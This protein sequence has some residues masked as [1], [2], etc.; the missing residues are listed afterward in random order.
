MSANSLHS[1]LGPSFKVPGADP[2]PPLDVFAKTPSGGGGG[3]A[4]A[5]RKAR[6]AAEAENER[7]FE[8]EHQRQD[9]VKDPPTKPKPVVKLSNGKWLVDK[10]HY[11]EKAKVSLDVERPSDVAADRITFEVCE[12]LPD[13]K[14]GKRHSAGE[15]HLGEGN[16]SVTCDLTLPQ[17]EKVDNKV[18]EKAY[19]QFVAKHLYSDELQG[20]RLEAMPGST[21]PFESVMY[22][23]PTRNQ[24]LLFESYEEYQ[25]LQDEIDSL[26]TLK[27]KSRQAFE[28]TDTGKRKEIGEEID[29][30]AN[31]L[32]EGKV[33]GEKE[34]TLEE[35][36]LVRKPVKWASPPGWA[37][38]RPHTD[39]DGKKI[40]GKWYKDTDPK[41]K[42][43]LED[44]MKKAPGSKEHSPFFSGELTLKLFKTKPLEAKKIAW[45]VKV[46]KEGTIAGQPFT[47]SKE[48]AVCRFMMGWDGAEATAN[49]KDKK[50]HIGGGGKISFGLFEGKMEGEFPWPEKGVNLLELL[51]K[52][53]YLDP[54]L[55]KGRQ[56]LMRLHFTLKADAFAGLT[57]GGALNLL[58]LNLTK[59]KLA[60]GEKK[61]RKV[62]T[63]A[64][65]KGF[66][67]GKADTGL[68]VGVEWA[69]SERDKFGELAN[70]GA[71]VGG[72]VGLGA[73]TEWKIEYRDGVFHF[74][75]GTG[76]TVAL[77]CKGK[78]SFEVGLEEGWHFVGYLLHCMDY[79][80][81]LEITDAAFS[82]YKNYAFTL[83]TLG[84]KA[85]TEDAFLI[86]ELIEHFPDWIAQRTVTQIEEAK[87]SLWS[88]TGYQ[89]AL[90]HV[91][92]EA[93]GQALI[94]IMKT[95]EEDD[96]RHILQILYSTM[97]PGADIK[98]DPTANHKLICTLQAVWALQLPENKMPGS[99]EEKKTALQKG[100][101]AILD[102][103]TGKSP[104]QPGKY[105]KQNGKFI[106]EFYSILE[107]YGVLQ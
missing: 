98:T 88:C 23:S 47:F 63:G 56:C 24:Y 15:A 80:E 25:P 84:G 93:L 20:P 79:H 87:R 19:F 38:I 41:I 8:E 10:G 99:D 48:A 95:R 1:S 30:E 89:G 60:N 64:E 51:S 14:R 42:E 18:P 67:G 21:S 33:V 29:K 85:L 62:G 52:S 61:G 68:T 22:Y 6:E 44:L 43:N 39:K 36:V 94:T 66:V 46:E 90:S 11:G 16:T 101:K 102:F 71:E 69:R 82:A 78:F 100:I 12:L 2:E 107:T 26:N 74:H 35:L 97:R 27:G 91:P 9:K 59:E 76:I 49:L 37:Y 96:F 65:G 55:A 17:P 77:G 86:K 92:P 5:K 50:I 72:S 57:V 70:C 75:A 53:E 40:K 103:G 54:I 34:T 3:G 58:D 45:N 4:A 73:E 28:A 32:F 105:T 81:V 104:N 106:D 7:H 13:G 83:M 31:K